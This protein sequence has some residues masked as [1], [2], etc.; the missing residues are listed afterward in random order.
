M[1]QKPLIM[2]PKAILLDTFG[3]QVAVFQHVNAQ[4]P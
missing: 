3:V 4:E 2:V 1:A